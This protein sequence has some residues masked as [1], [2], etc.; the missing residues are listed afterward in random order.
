[1]EEEKRQI[2][3][4]Q[5]WLEGKISSKDAARFSADASFDALEKIVDASQHLDVPRVT[6]KEEAWQKLEDNISKKSS[7]KII[8][9][10]RRNWIIGVAASFT[11]ALGAFFLFPSGEENEI[12]ETT[13]AQNDVM[14]LPDGS[15]IHLNAVSSAGYNAESYDKKR[16]ITLEGEAF[17]EVVKG[18][19]FSVRTDEGTVTVLGTSFNVRSRNGELTVACKTGKVGVTPIDSDEMIILT[20]GERVKITKQDQQIIGEVEKINTNRIASWIKNEFDFESMSIQDVFKEVERQYNIRIESTFDQATLEETMTGTI[21]TDNLEE[22]I[23][24]LEFMKNIE[25]TVSDN[26]KTIIFKKK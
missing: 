26:G 14:S 5:Q 10:S 9:I 7:P 23:Q 25:A 8:S 24:T 4:E 16:Q 12:H 18:K 20:P 17:F 21:A 22:A 3:W 15:I 19:Q 1:M 11:L 2:K 13:Y 6:S